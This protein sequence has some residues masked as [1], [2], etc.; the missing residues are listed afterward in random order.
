MAIVILFIGYTS[1][2]SAI[3]AA[4]TAAGV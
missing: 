3:R 2:L 1:V 4:T